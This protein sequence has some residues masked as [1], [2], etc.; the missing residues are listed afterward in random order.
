MHKRHGCTSCGE[1]QCDGVPSLWLCAPTAMR[2]SPVLL[3]CG[4]SAGLVPRRP[5]FEAGWG[6]LQAHTM[7]INTC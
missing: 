5:R 3:R 1:G 6:S 2:T 7:I 4:Q